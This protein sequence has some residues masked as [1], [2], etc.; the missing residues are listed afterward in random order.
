ME[1]QKTT[2]TNEVASKG[3]ATRERKHTMSEDTETFAFQ[4]EI[5]Q[6]LSLIINVRTKERCV[7]I[8]SYPWTRR[9]AIARVASSAF[10]AMRFFWRESVE[11]CA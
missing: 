10:Y 3:V 11:R 5:N 8:D 6:L 7:R 1:S 4:A 2:T 9:R